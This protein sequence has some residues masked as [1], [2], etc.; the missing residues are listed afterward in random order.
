VVVL[1][2]AVLGVGA[3]AFFLVGDGAVGDCV[4]RYQY[5]GTVRHQG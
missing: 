2:V 4:L 5:E 3:A 1:V